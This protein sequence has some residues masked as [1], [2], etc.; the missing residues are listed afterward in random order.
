MTI[1]EL[2]DLSKIIKVNYLCEQTGLD[3]SKI[4]RKIRL[5]IELSERE[6]RILSEYLKTHFQEEL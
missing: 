4:T 2:T 6:D 1:K 3:Y 5:G